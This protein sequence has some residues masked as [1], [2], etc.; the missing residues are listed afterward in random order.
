MRGRV[1]MD[2]GDRGWS[3]Q[4]TVAQHAEAWLESTDN[5]DEV[6]VS[7]D[8]GATACKGAVRV[9]GRQRRHR[10]GLKSKFWQHNGS[11]KKTPGLVLR[12]GT[13]EHK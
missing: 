1:S 5:G 7:T 9:H 13:R 6:E 12:G 4:T 10:G 3:P 11:G 2:D 8:D